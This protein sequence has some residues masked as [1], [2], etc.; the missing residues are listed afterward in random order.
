MFLRRVIYRI[1]DREN[2]INKNQDFLMGH[3]N[4]KTT[5]K[6]S[7]ICK[8]MSLHIYLLIV[9]TT[10]FVIQLFIDGSMKL[11]IV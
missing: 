7:D 10:G 3:F 1:V 9:E 4:H 8:K 6:K 5:G 11:V 2:I